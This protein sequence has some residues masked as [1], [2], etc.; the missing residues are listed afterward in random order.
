VEGM[1]KKLEIYQ[2]FF[3]FPLKGALQQTRPSEGG[4]DTVTFSTPPT[5]C[6]GEPGASSR[7]YWD[8]L[9]RTAPGLMSPLSQQDSPC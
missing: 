6:A 7:S 4:V 8:S 9:A 5:L 1:G 2:F 3:P